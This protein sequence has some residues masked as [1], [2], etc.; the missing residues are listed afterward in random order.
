MKTYFIPLVL[1]VI[2]AGISCKKDKPPGEKKVKVTTVAGEGKAAFADGPATS[3]GFY[4]P[5]DVVVTPDGTIYV[6]DLFNSRIRKIAA[7]QVFTF[8]GNSTQSIVNGNGLSASFIYPNR[9]ALD[10]NGNL[11][12]LDG[13]DPRIR[14]ISPAADVSTYAGTESPGFN[15]GNA[16]VAR[17]KEAG[18]GIVADARGNIYVADTY[19][20]RIRKV[21]LSGEVTT[22]AGNGTAGFNNGNGGTAQFFNPGG[23]AID[24][25]GNLYISDRGNYRIRRI[26]PGGQVSTFAGSGLQGDEDG[27][28]ALARFN[29]PLDLVIDNEGNLY[30]T[31]N[32]RIRKISAQGVV[33]TVAGST[34]GY[35]DGDGVSAKF[36]YPAGMGLDAQGNIYVGDLLNNRIRKI[37]FE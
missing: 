21:S 12:I 26:T 22:I 13:V 30:V 6:T 8:A 16:D 28:A 23:I 1:V 3:A 5:E 18:G 11:Y 36:Y 9:I 2:A 34:P 27:T 7:G 25:Q 10:V 14:K 37:S 19:N 33:S 35:A 20:N 24:Q 15:D 31:D 29:A 17:F 4:A 32:H